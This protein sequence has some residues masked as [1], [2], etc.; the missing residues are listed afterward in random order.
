MRAM[1][2]AAGRG[3]R[4]RPLTH[5]IPKPLLDVGGKSLIEYQI[6]RLVKAGITD[7]VINHGR[8]G[9]QIEERL[10]DGKR[11]SA[12]INYSAEGDQ[13]LETGGGIF[14]ALEL[15]GN[16][17]FIAVNSDVWSDYPLER[18]PADPNGLAHL[19]LVANP[20]HHFGGDFGLDGDT[21]V[22]EGGPRLTFSGIA[23]YRP[24]LFDECGPG[25]FPLAP[26][27][28]HAIVRRLVSGERYQGTWIDVGTPERLEEVRRFC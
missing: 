25:R 10:G 28:R 23:V 21:V 9:R 12:S 14:K 13:P 7:L 1:I 26:I 16:K 15:L 5:D 2:L 20:A 24:I 22:L 18:L 11:Y 6:E 17:P 19:V 4:M 8:H 3:E 27:L